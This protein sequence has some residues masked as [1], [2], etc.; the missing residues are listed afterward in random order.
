MPPPVQQR[1]VYSSNRVY[2]FTYK[3]DNIFGHVV[4]I[5][6]NQLPVKVRLAIDTSCCLELSLTIELSPSSDAH[7]NID[8]TS[9]SALAIPDNSYVLKLIRLFFVDNG[10]NTQLDAYVRY[11]FMSIYTSSCIKKNAQHNLV[12]PHWRQMNP[13]L[14]A[15]AISQC[16]VVFAYAAI[17]CTTSSFW[18]FVFSSLS[19]HDTL[20]QSFALS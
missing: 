14:V 2:L 16:F 12:S 17:F 4:W 1:F 20:I 15:L 7:N 10:P 13:L 6:N 3:Q 5:S 8:I 18:Y 11:F 19:I 9:F